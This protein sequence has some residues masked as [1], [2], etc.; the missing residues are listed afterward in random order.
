MFL[1]SE[2]WVLKQLKQVSIVNILHITHY[3][4]PSWQEKKPNIKT[5]MARVNF[6]DSWHLMIIVFCKSW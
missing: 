2:E 6:G 3:T 4:V 1:V 5:Y